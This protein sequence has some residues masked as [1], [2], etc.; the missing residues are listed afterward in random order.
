MHK[1]SDYLPKHRFQCHVLNDDTT[2]ILEEEKELGLN[3]DGFYAIAIANKH[4]VRFKRM[5]EVSIYDDDIISFIERS[6]YHACD[7]SYK[8]PE[9]FY[10]T[11]V[12][13]DNK[14]MGF[15]YVGLD[16]ADIEQFYLNMADC[17]F[18]KENVILNTVKYED[19]HI[20]VRH[21]TATHKDGVTIIFS[22]A[23]KE[24]IIKQVLQ[25]AS[26]QDKS[27]VSRRIR[28][29]ES[30]LLIQIAEKYKPHKHDLT[31]EV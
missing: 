13:Y 10:F 25:C 24:L 20:D 7:L 11:C 29:A 5:D 28:E 9:C 3:G 6:F 16:V 31:S 14:I 2:T 27:P 12:V 21:L 23:D 18:V 22:K 26:G 4:I 1:I 8:E 17:F 15:E 19:W 30:A